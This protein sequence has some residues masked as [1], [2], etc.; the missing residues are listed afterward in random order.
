M[1]FRFY[2][3]FVLAVAEALPLGIHN[4]VP[5]EFK[6]VMTSLLTLQRPEGMSDKT[7]YL[8]IVFLFSPPPCQ[9]GRG[10]NGGYATPCHWGRWLH[11]QLE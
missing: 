4:E 2:L 3:Y 1:L 9:L 8:G 7:F 11:T 10:S 6:R 5:D